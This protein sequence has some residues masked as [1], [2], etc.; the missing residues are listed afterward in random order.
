MFTA[1]YGKSLCYALFLVTVRQKLRGAMS[2][3]VAIISVVSVNYP[4]KIAACGD[5]LNVGMYPDP[6]SSPY[7]YIYMK[8]LIR[9]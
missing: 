1:R 2:R 6:S 4:R 3:T 5:N 7:I 9:K 8:G